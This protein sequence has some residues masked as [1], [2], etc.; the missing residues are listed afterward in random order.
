MDFNKSKILVAGASGALG[1]EIVKLLK[2]KGYPLRLITSSTQGKEKLSGYS[3]DVVIVDATRGDE[4]LEGITHGIDIII[5]ALG[6]SISLFK[7]NEDSFYEADY[8][9]NMKILRD[10]E[11]NATTR[12]LYVSINGAEEN[13]EHAIAKSH[14]LFEKQL[15]ASSLRHSIFRPVGFFAGLEDLAVFAKRG[16]IPVIEDGQ[17]RTNCIHHK[18]LA[19]AIVDNLEDG[20]EIFEIGGPEILTRMEIAKIIQNN[21]GGEIIKMPKVI[22]DLGLSLPKIFDDLHNKLE[23]FN[24]VMTHD[25]IGN[26]TGTQKLDQYFKELNKEEIK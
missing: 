9:A 20:P 18:D 5:S 4:S 2:R 24:Y 6:N 15:K 1:M 21:F 3:N 14:R 26:K 19:K 10:A 8:E 22:A 11:K 16:I 12:F 23:Y 13:K 17:A 25:M 7:P